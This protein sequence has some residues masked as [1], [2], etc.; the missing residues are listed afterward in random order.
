MSSSVTPRTRALLQDSL[1]YAAVAASVGAIAPA[2]SAQIVYTDLNPDVTVA[3]TFDGG[4]LAG[5]SFDLDGDG[6]D[7]ILIAERGLTTPSRY[8][9]AAFGTVTGFVGNVVPYAGVDYGYF[10]PLAL[11]SAIGPSSANFLPVGTGSSSFSL[12]TF[13]FGASD[14]NSWRGTEAYIG[15]SFDVG[16]NTHYGWMRL[17]FGANGDQII[18][19]DYAYQATPSAP[20]NAGDRGAVATEPDALSEG[21]RFSPMAPNPTTGRSSFDLAVGQAETV[22]VEAFD[23]LGRS[24]AVLHD[25]PMA[26][27]QTARLTLDASSLPAGVYVVRAA[28][29]SFVTARRVS[30]AH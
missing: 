6:N 8:G 18:V 25:G 30:V 5:A 11:G 12:G 16:P 21:Y 26:A 3:N 13:T 4:T 9:L 28:G 10:L 15:L 23:A 2:A 22:R 27:G 17:Q 1:W 29:E 24:V 19:K 20:I 7:E 14:P